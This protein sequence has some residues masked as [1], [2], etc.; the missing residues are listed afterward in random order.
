MDSHE[1]RRH[2][3][4]VAH[5]A[6]LGVRV[7]ATELAAC[8]EAGAL[9]LV[10]TITDQADVAGSKERVISVA[11]DSPPE[12]LQ[13]FL[14]AVLKLFDVEAFVFGRVEAEVFDGRARARLWGERFD[15]D[16]HGRGRE[17][18]AVT[19]HELELERSESGYR[20]YFLLDI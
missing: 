11:S 4:Y 12:L 5:T 7:E 15:P 13:A 1:A 19:R 3:E 16:R 14:Q 9:A 20:A 18:K 8:F 17:V 10:D 2:Y 6:D